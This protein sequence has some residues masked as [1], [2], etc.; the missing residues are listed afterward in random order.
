VLFEK[1][2]PIKPELVLEGGNVAWSAGTGVDAPIDDLSLLTTS[3][4]PASG[5]LSVGLCNATSAATA[6]LAR[7]AALVWTEYPSLWPETVR[8]LLVH[9]AEW[10]PA[11]RLRFEADKRKTS[12][13]ALLRRYG[14]GVPLLERALHSAS[15]ALTLVKEATIFPFSPAG[16]F[17]EA[18]FHALPWPTEQLQALGVAEVRL[19]VTLSYFVEPNPARRGWRSRYRYASY[20]LRFKVKNATESKEAFYK[21][22]NDDAREEDDDSHESNDGWYLGS[23]ARDRGSIHSDFC[24]STAAELAERSLIAVVP[25]SGWRKKTLKKNETPITVRYALIVSIDAP[26][27]DVDLWTPVFSAIQRIELTT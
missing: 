8:A 21:R 15:D 19:R 6:Q 22:V 4:D 7:L 27:V 24:T 16:T 23:T 10:T 17:G 2:W 1:S 26:G 18:H 5:S 25:V 13:A 12:R 9:A 3:F 20:G 11:M 14:Y